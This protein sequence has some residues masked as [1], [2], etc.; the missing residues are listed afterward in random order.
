MYMQTIIY[1]AKI[2]KN[3]FANKCNE[4]PYKYIITIVYK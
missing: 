4:L 3:S 1:L 2:S